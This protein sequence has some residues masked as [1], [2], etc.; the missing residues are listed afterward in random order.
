M[1]R[2]LQSAGPA[3]KIILGGLLLI[4]CGGMIITLIPGGLASSF[5]V[6]APPR[7]VIA[8]VDDQ[9]VTVPEVQRT[10]RVMIRQQFPK[11]GEQAAMLMPFFA[12]QAAE[13]LINLKALV[14]EAR[15]MGLRVSDE[16]LRDELQHGPLASML[17]PDGKFVG[18]EEY[19]NFAQR[20]DLTIPQFESLEKEYILIRKLRALISGSAFVGDP[21]IRAEFDRRNTKVKFDYAVLTQADILKGLHPT[22]QELKA[23]YDRNKATYNN[24]VPEKRQ[25]KY[26]IVETA[27]SGASVTDQESQAYY[28]QHRDEYR[29]PEQVKVAHILI[30]TPL[31]GPDGKVDEKGVEAGRKKAEDVL[32]QVKAGGD[33]AKLAG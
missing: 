11:G 7:G 29:L 31:P 15:R 2:T 10:A 6:G 20:A 1:I 16:E 32:K 18:Q 5:G 19:E 22:D 33:F 4:I 14:A 28:D 24:S 9:E 12:G 13:Q 21:E 26:V 25:I 30:K 27:K 23:F 8:R 3:L 17:F